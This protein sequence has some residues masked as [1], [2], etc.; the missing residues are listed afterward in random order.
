[1]ITN[2]MK[3]ICFGNENEYQRL[4]A[5]NELE[6]SRPGKCRCYYFRKMKKI[7]LFF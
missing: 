6:R 5:S 1:M 4:F 7:S 3:T 2:E